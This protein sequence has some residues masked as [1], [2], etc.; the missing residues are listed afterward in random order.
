M[1]LQ[2]LNDVPPTYDGL[3]KKL[4]FG[5]EIDFLDSHCYFHLSILDFGKT[6]HSVS[7]LIEYFMGARK[8]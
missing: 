7:R 6:Y 4:F 8:I 3:S 2:E 1:I 5:N